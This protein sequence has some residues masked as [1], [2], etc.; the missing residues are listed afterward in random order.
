MKALTGL[1]LAGTALYD[2]GR[3]SE[4]PLERIMRDP[5]NPRTPFHLRT[6]DDQ[7]KQRELN[8]NIKKRGVKSPISL[9]PHPYLA[10]TWIINHGHCRYDG[11][12][13]AGHATIPYFLD[14]NFDCYDQVAENLH[15]CELSIWAIAEFIAR[16]LADGDT[17]GHI[18][19][20]LGQESPAFVSAHLALIE[21]PG[22]LHQ[23][24]ANGVKSVRTLYDLRRAYEE[25]P[26]QVDAWCKGNPSITRDTIKEL[27]AALR[28]P[29]VARRV[30]GLAPGESDVVRSGLTELDAS[31]MNPQRQANNM[32]SSSSIDAGA[33]AFCHDKAASSNVAGRGT[34]QICHDK[35]A[36]SDAADPGTTS[37]KVASARSSS[38]VASAT[39]QGITIQYKGKC[40]ELI[41]NAM[42]EVIVEDQALP[43]E[44]PL[45]ELELSSRRRN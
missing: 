24:H 44:V 41:S 18:A 13:A 20:R 34:R 3:P 36:P 14:Q 39:A 27:L 9:R 16:K 1:R 15:R 28:H 2:V 8:E 32:A 12:L 37:A 6:P 17:K 43:I 31:E 29:A 19:E 35:V 5:A 10:D 21:A 33:E 23:A 45:F 11:A 40:A 22:C 7:Q 4:M 38:L 30:C 26:D 25:F 42:V